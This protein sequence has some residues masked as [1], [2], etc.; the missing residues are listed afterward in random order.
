MWLFSILKRF[1]A[2]KKKG[3]LNKPLVK[4]VMKVWSDGY[5]DHAFMLASNYDRIEIGFQQEIL[6]INEKISGANGS[7]EQDYIDYLTDVGNEVIGSKNKLQAYTT[8]ILYHYVENE[9]KKIFKLVKYEPRGSSFDS[10][11][12]CLKRNGVIIAN[13]NISD[14][15]KVN[16]LRRLNNCL[17]HN[18]GL[19]DKK[20][21]NLNP[22]FVI[23]QIIEL[24]KTDI[25]NYTSSVVNFLKSLS[26]K[27]DSAL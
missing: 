15:T 26:T 21:N 2:K 18:N 22:K 7:A 1:L 24:D 27:V 6:D 19:A 14:Y 23:N 4:F 13:T 20:L 16:E 17:K 8:T 25:S 10:L 9:I 11:L 12:R 5:E 3:D